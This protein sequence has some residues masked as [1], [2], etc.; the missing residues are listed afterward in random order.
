MYT[1][2]SVLMLDSWQD[3]LVLLVIAVF[4]FGGSKLAGL[5]KASGRALREFKEET[6]SLH[7]GSSSDTSAAPAA[8]A[9]QTA[10]TDR[11]A[12]NQSVSGQTVPGQATRHQAA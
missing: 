9:T 1:G 11:P 4:L 7:S 12:I 10:A 8:E 3:L 6:Q 5:G 2:I